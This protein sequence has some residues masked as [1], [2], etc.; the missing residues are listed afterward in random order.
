MRLTRLTQ[1]LVKEALFNILA[2]RIAGASFLDLYAGEGGVGLGALERGAERVVFVENNGRRIGIIREQL[3]R[4]VKEKKARVYRGD[5]L[6]ML[7]R[8]EINFDIIFL[9]PPYNKGLVIP[10]LNLISKAEITPTVIV[11]AEHHYKEE[12]PHQIGSLRLTKEKRYGETFLSFYP[13]CSY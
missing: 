7:K 10:T 1:G 8:M 5:V 4:V 9:D 11:V 6:K 3:K 13:A 2:D 12:L